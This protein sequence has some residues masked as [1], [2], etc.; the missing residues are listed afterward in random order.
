MINGLVSDPSDEIN[1]LEML[2]QA[3]KMLEQ[4]KE[5]AKT[6]TTATKE[7]DYYKQVGR[8]I[9][10]LDTYIYSEDPVEEEEKKINEICDSLKKLPISDNV[11]GGFNLHNQL[12]WTFY[13]SQTKADQSHK[14][15]L[16]KLKNV[17]KRLDKERQNKILQFMARELE[18]D[19]LMNTLFLR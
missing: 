10:L 19:H 6:G 2:E 18:K 8:S 15:K 17:F 3:K 13:E 5:N 9:E 11:I 7:I 16:N 14:A 12:L 4:A 1:F